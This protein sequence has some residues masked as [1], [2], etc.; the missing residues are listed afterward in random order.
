MSFPN[1][2]A[3]RLELG[4]THYRLLMRVN[5]FKARAF[6]EIECAK[7]HRSSRE[8]ERQIGSLLCERLAMSRD[9]KSVARLSKKGQVVQK[10]DDLIKDPYVLQHAGGK[11]RKMFNFVFKVRIVHFFK[12]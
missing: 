3:L 10:Y 2:D 6:Y 7:N 4:W 9:K 5:D 1:R 12:L 8:L 11:D